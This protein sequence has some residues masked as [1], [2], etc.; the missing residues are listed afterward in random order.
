M[1]AHFWSLAVEEQF[2]LFWP[3]LVFST[4]PRT[5][6]RICVAVAV[7]ALAAR[8]LLLR[9]GAP[10]MMVYRLTLTKVD[11]LVLGGLAAIVLRDPTWL[12]AVYPRLRAAAAV[13]VGLL[14]SP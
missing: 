5:L 11:P 7:G 8:V 10:D 1:L 6:A 2:Y 4:R 13:L 14:V 3:A 9:L 12:R